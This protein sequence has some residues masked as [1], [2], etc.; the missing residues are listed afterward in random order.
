[1]FRDICKVSVNVESR[2][3][4]GICNRSKQFI[5]NPEEFSDKGTEVA[6]VKLEGKAYVSL[7]NELKIRPAHL[8]DTLTAIP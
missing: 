1:M 7:E 2:E 8:P 3:N 4:G 5:E 6:I